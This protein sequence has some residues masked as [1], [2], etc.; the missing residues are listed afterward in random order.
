MVSKFPHEADAAGPGIKDLPDVLGLQIQSMKETAY[1]CWW[2][3]KRGR[4]RQGGTEWGILSCSGAMV[5]AFP[6]ESA[7]E[8]A[9]WTT[10]CWEVTTPD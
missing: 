4:L 7:G 8:S 2:S 6:L 9:A 1:R 5:E 10:S 3:L